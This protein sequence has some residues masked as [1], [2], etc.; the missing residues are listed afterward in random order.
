MSP[1]FSS[2]RTR[3][4]M[5]TMVSVIIGTILTGLVVA[6]VIHSY[7]VDSFHAEMEIHIQELSEL[8][9]VDAKGQPYLLRRLSDP[10]FI[11]PGSGFYWEVER[12]G[13]TTIR[14]PS[15]DGNN[16]PVG[17]AKGPRPLWQFILGPTGST[18]EYAMT[19][20]MT[21]GGP[22]L[23]LYVATDQ[24]LIDEL[25]AE[26]DWPLIYSL[27]VFAIVMIL[28]GAIQINYGMRPLRKMQAAISA[29]RN[30][31]ER[32]MLGD[33]PSE[34]KPLVSDLNQLLTSNWDM[35]QSARVQAGN[36]AHGLRT[37]LAI[38]ADEAQLLADKGGRESANVL[39][40]SCEQMQ[41]YIDYYTS[42][43]RMAAQANLP[44]HRAAVDKVLEP[45]ISAMR[46]LHRDRG[47]TLAV[48]YGPKIDVS[49]DEVDLAE[50][51]SNLIDNA[52]KWATSRIEITWHLDDGAT[53]LSIDDDGPGIAEGHRDTVF[54][55]GERLDMAKFGTGLGLAI[56]KDILLHYQGS[57]EL[58]KSPLGGLGVRLRLPF[59]P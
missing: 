10:R 35:V 45:I 7:V 39:L 27:G 5:A 49:V 38:I 23:K 56:V 25:V 54:K 11:P 14:S 32:R 30:G 51:L 47:L 52:C 8:S 6:R 40:Q 31:R 17:L 19:K 3:F 57:I 15:L 50:I 41:R 34:I 22:P 24:R 48:A 1:D 12:A 58:D 21:D 37:P 2:L 28:I 55:V 9:V 4:I 29:I 26:I 16:L 43:A 36:L 46:R 13:F 20:P 42:R 59:R 33:Y 44:G 18:L 53:V